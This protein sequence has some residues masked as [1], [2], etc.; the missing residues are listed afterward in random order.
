M[1]ARTLRAQPVQTHLNADEAHIVYGGK[2]LHS[3]V[4]PAVRL[5]I[6]HH[7]AHSGACRGEG[8]QVLRASGAHAAWVRRRAPA[9][10]LAVVIYEHDAPLVLHPGS[11]LRD[12]KKTS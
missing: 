11:Q 4:V 7:V 1:T 2:A 5:R 9:C 12:G 10:T 8:T 6:R 3:W